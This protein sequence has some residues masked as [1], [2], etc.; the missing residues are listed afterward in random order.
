MGYISGVLQRAEARAPK[1]NANCIPC[2][3]I[4]L[5]ADEI[6]DYNS[7]HLVLVEPQ[8]LLIL[9]LSR[10]LHQ[11]RLGVIALAK[12]E[13]VFIKRYEQWEKAKQAMEKQMAVY[14]T[15]QW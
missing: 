5:A 4:T 11:E 13:R 1:A 10:L 12:S 8:S 15:Y 14:E 3:G 7:P 9:E 6:N 2:G